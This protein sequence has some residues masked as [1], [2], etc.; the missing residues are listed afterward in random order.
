M[1]TRRL[2][3]TDWPLIDAARAAA[4]LRLPTELWLA[5]SGLLQLRVY[6]YVAFAM[7]KTV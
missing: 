5:A 7:E 3:S 6:A 4:V 1:R 2:N